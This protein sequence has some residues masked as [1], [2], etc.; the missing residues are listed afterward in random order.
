M[1]LDDRVAGVHQDGIAV[2]ELKRWQG[3]SQQEVVEVDLG[4][5]GA[6]A[7]HGD[8]AVAAQA[9]VDTTGLLEKEQD[10]VGGHAGVASGPLDTTGYEHCYRLG[11]EQV[12]VDLEATR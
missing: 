6:P 1:Y 9:R 7:Q 4:E 12:G 2:L 8:V 11:R 3:S 10:R 5:L